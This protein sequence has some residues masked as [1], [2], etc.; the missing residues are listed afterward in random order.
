[1]NLILPVI[2]FLWFLSEVLVNRLLRA[3]KSRE[4]LDPDK[5]SLTFIWITIIISIFTSVF[6]S[7]TIRSPI[8][9]YYIQ[10]VGVF[11]ILAGMVIRFTAIR[12]LGK[13]FT[14][15]LSV[16]NEQ[17]L[18]HHGFY[19][20]IRHPSYSGSLLSFLG[21]GFTLN[22]WVSLALTVIPV[23][24]VFLYRIRLEE[25]LLI[26]QPGLGYRD[27]MKRTKRLIPKIY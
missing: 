27:Y 21:F 16:K 20:Y 4:D 2:W 14:V 6:S 15:D 19:K 26:K 8:G 10:Y 3:G 22:N 1:M 18:I 23:T 12:T 25:Q 11:L 9:P 13:A 7:Y 17:K 5:G 24:L